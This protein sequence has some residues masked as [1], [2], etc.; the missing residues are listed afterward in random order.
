MRSAYTLICSRR[1]AAN[2][3]RIWLWIQVFGC[4]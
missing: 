1:P 2:G 3:C 4:Y